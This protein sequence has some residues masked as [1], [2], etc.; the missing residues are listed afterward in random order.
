MLEIDLNGVN[1][2]SDSTRFDNKFF[3]TI[4]QW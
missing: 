4:A 1:P 3:L 2:G